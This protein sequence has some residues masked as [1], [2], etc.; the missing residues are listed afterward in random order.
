MGLVPGVGDLLALAPAAYI[1]GSARRMGAPAPLMGRMLF[2]TGVDTVFGA[3][4]L[5][6]DLFDVGWKGNLRN[7]ALLRRHLQA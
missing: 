1:I 4:P 3:I 6:G 2:N 5:L 7:A